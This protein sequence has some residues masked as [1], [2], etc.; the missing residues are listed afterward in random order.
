[1]PD[2]LFMTAHRLGLIHPFVRFSARLRSEILQA[3]KF[4]TDLVTNRLIYIDMV[5]DSLMHSVLPVNRFATNS[6]AETSFI[7]LFD[8][9][10]EYFG[11]KHVFAIA[12]GRTAELV[13]AKANKLESGLIPNNVLF[14]TTRFHQELAGAELLEIPVDEAYDL[15]SDCPF[16]GNVDTEKLQKAISDHGAERF[17]YIYV[18]TCVNASGGHPVSMENISAVHEIAKEHGIPVILDACRILENA[19]LIRTREPGYAG[20][21]LRDIVREF[22][23]HSDGCTMSATKDFLVDT[24]GFIA[25]NDDEQRY[26]IQDAMMV[27]GEG[28]SVRSKAVLNDSIIRGFRREKWVRDRVEKSAHLW[29]GL[30]QRGVPVVHPAGGHGVFIDASE[31]F[32]HLPEEKHPEKAFLVQLYL[33]SGIMA[34][35][36]MLSPAQREKGIRMIRLAVPM[37]RYSLGRMDYVA[38]SVAALWQRLGELKGLKKVYEQP[39]LSGSFLAEYERE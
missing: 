17:P 25:T 31:L 3:T 26:R 33:D 29:R 10:R 2:K 5:T 36:N 14:V 28:L 18:E 1:M 38:K 20:K 8:T 16:K 9:F 35:E 6:S 11:Y 32:E 23:S 22:C 4:N 19:W 27:I 15:Q 12:Q 39:C 34:S 30:K 37:A 24:G 21:S 7:S 13:F